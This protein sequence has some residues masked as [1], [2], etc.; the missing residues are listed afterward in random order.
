MNNKL[1]CLRK[2]LETGVQDKRKELEAKHA[3]ELEQL[4]TELEN[5]YREVELFLCLVL[6][7]L[8]LCH[9]L[10]YITLQNK[11]VIRQIQKCPT[12]KYIVH[13]KCTVK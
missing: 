12:A 7:Y 4:R 11:F 10:H 13:L 1:E 6:F 3:A 5:K 9:I 2:R 8:T